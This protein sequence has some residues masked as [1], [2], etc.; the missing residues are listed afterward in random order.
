MMKVFFDEVE[1]TQLLKVVNVQRGIMPERT[2]YTVEVPSRHGAYYT[3]HKYGARTVSI[4][5]LMLG[6]DLN[7]LQALKKALAFMLD[8]D[9]PAKLKFDD[10]PDKLLYAVLD[11]STDVDEILKEGRGT[12]T[13]IC[14]DPFYYAEAEKEFTGA[15]GGLMTINNLGTISTDPRFT[16]DF[17]GD[18]G[19]IALASPDGVIQIGNTSQVDEVA[20][21]KQ[22][23]LLHLNMTTNTGWTINSAS[24]KLKTGS[25][26]VRGTMGNTTVGAKPT[27]YGTAT[28]GWTGPS[29]RRDIPASI[30]ATG[31]ARYF[32]ATFMFEFKSEKAGQVT[33]STVK[34]DIDAAQKGILEISIT[35]ENNDYLAGIRFADATVYHDMAVPEFWVGG[36]L[37][38]KEDLKK[39]APKREKYTYK[40]GGKVKTGYRTVY[41]SDVGKW[42]D[43]YGSIT[44]KKYWDRIVFD[45]QKIEK[46]KGVLKVVARKTYTHYLSETQKN[47]KA[48]SIQ[49]WFGRYASEP[50]I[51]KVALNQVIFRKL[52]TTSKFDVPN[53]FQS[54]DQLVIDCESN[55]V[56][57]NGALFMEQVDIGSEF[58]EVVAGQTEIQ[59]MHSS[60]TGVTAPTF[61]GYITERWL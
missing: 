39:P 24:T 32:E 6:S 52:N 46:V 56:F 41:A 12:L 22:E 34:R 5:F 28:T 23:K 54:G 43:F 36:Q 29:L 55:Q 4:D 44:I 13:F 33:T 42:N 35:D 3:G 45:L 21:P 49:S 8:I 61:K 47:Q 58:F 17:T 38:W 15:S 30:D 31:L 37:V 59:L 19:F 40:S 16:L 53:T 1:I 60:F 7:S 20:L 57:L 27:S 2:N 14:H 26:S 18:C 50:F 25:S 48:K 10:E 51:D 9:R 11:G